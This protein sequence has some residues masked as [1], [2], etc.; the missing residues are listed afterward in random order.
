MFVL[1]ILFVQ[2]H[3][4]PKKKEFKGN[5]LLLKPMLYVLKNISAA[6]NKLILLLV[7]IS[8]LI[9]FNCMHKINFLFRN[10]KKFGM[11]EFHQK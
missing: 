4:Y 10:F 1:T 11:K 9:H 6:Q 7:A 5:V 8:V 3:I 2:I